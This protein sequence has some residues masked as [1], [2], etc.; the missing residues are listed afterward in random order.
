[1]DVLIGTTNPAK[2]NRFQKL[3]DG[4]DIRLITPA[5]LQITESPEETGRDP[6]ENAQIKA[7]FYGQYCDY[8]IANDS[9]LIFLD[10]P[11]ND[12]RQPGLHV[13]SPQ[14]VRLND[15]EMIAYYSALAHSLGGRIRA[16]YADA[17]AVFSKGKMFSFRDSEKTLHDIAFYLLDT[18]SPNRTPGWPLDSLSY[19]P[20]T[21]HYFVDRCDHSPSMHQLQAIAEQKLFLR[22]ALGLA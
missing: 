9:G 22:T 12:P 16:S 4:C 3:L 11:R 18:A 5:D 10:L 14:G 2:V 6:L 8:A 21:G 13:R 7:A 1:M 15:E 17:I 19:H 20:Q